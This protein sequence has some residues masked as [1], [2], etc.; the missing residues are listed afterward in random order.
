MDFFGSVVFSVPYSSG[1]LTAVALPEMGSYV[2][3][4]FSRFSFGEANA[5]HLSLDAPHASTGTGN[6][7]LLDG[8]DTAMVRAEVVDH[9][10][11]N[12]FFLS[13]HQFLHKHA[14]LNS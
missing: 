3:A 12:P 7:L 11:K 2:L 13:T 5:I 1:N 8:E 10:G 9:D 6:A 14:S 4:S